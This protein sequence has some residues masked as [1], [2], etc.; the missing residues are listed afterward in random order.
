M[1]RGSNI[2]VKGVRAIDKMAM[3]NMKVCLAVDLCNCDLP[4]GSDCSLFTGK[5]LYN[6]SIITSF[7]ELLVKEFYV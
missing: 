1:L 5:N 7:I 4:R 2:F 3:K 6:V